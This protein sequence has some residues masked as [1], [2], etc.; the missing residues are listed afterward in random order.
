MEA[1]FK[2]SAVTS[3]VLG[4]SSPTNSA[5]WIALLDTLNTITISVTLSLLNNRC[6]AAGDCFGAG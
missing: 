3:Q 2:R 6:R 4:L 5:E 1:V